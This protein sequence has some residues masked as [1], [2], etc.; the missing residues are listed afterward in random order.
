MRWYTVTSLRR[1]DAVGKGV[2]RA[3][4]EPSAAVLPRRVSGRFRGA[5]G[6]EG[7]DGHDTNG[8]GRG[9]SRVP[10]RGKVR[11]GRRG[12]RGGGRVR[13]SDAI[14]WLARSPAGDGVRDG[15]RS[16]Q[17]TGGHTAAT[18]SGVEGGWGRCLPGLLKLYPAACQKM[19]ILVGSG[20]KSHRFE[21][22]S[23]DG[24]RGSACFRCLRAPGRRIIRGLRGHGGPASPG[25]G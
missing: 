13:G 19:T 17:A 4:W 9:W 12:G 21:L 23:H 8:A 6:R 15:V 2:L 25:S 16:A 18:S 10:V 24:S 1:G 22:P 20:V 7:V 14:G 11:P 5:A 3:G